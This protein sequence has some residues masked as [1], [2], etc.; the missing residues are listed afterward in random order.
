MWLNEQE[1]AENGEKVYRQW[2]HPMLTR[3]AFPNEFYRQKEYRSRISDKMTHCLS[4]S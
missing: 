1:E 3:E 2:L 4:S